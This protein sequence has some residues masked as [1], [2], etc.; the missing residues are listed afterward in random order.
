[1]TASIKTVVTPKIKSGIPS[2]LNSELTL[3]SGQVI[4]LMRN[5]ELETPVLEEQKEK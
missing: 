3:N 2:L 1:M 5:S 4:H